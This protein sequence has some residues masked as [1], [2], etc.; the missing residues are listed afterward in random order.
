MGRYSD[1]QSQSGDDHVH[2]TWFFNSQIK[3]CELRSVKTKTAGRRFLFLSGGATQS[4]TGLNGFA[5]RCITALLSR[6]KAK[7]SPRK[8][9]GKHTRFP[10]KFG[11][12][13]ETRTRDLYLGKVS[14]YQL[15]YSRKKRSPH[16]MDIVKCV[17]K[18]ATLFFRIRVHNHLNI[19]RNNSILA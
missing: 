13:N 11:A 6:R 19:C 5:I 17:K 16:Y 3:H 7:C 10:L 15:S 18:I 1:R 2:R 12:G 9:K 4:R 8:T 14:L